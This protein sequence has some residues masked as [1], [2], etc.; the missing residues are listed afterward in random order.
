MIHANPTQPDQWGKKRLR[1]F[2][3]ADADSAGII[4]NARAR[5]TFCG[6]SDVLPPSPAAAEARAEISRNDFYTKVLI[7]IMDKPVRVKTKLDIPIEIRNLGEVELDDMYSA[8]LW[9]WNIDHANIAKVKI[10]PVYVGAPISQKRANESQ[11]HATLKYYGIT[12][13]MNQGYENIKIEKSYPSGIADVCCQELKFALECG[14]TE[15]NRILTA[16]EYGWTVGWLRYKFIVSSD[17][18]YNTLYPMLVFSPID[19]QSLDS[20]F[21]VMT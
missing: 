1:H 9:V 15:P 20:I 10:H 3:Q 18:E 11:L 21:E 5:S 4:L 7:N 2:L 8:C 14:N 13:L 19:G 17:A 6:D 16:I 12:W